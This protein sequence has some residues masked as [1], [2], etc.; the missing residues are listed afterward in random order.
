LEEQF[1][2]SHLAPGSDDL[3]QLGTAFLHRSSD[4][5]LVTFALTPFFGCVHFRKP[6][7]GVDHTSRCSSSRVTDTVRVLD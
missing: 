2:I 7:I 6:I 1:Q 4:T 5:F 3:V